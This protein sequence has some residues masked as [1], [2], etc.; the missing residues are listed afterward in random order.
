M[1]NDMIKQYQSITC[2]QKPRDFSVPIK[3]PEP[4]HN[5]TPKNNISPQNNMTVPAINMP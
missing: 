3:S 1:H 4:K 2:T 5:P